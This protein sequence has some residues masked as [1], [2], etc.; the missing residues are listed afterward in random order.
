MDQSLKNAIAGNIEKKLSGTSYI[1]SS[2]YRNKQPLLNAC[3]DIADHF[4]DAIWL[5]IFNG[6]MPNHNFKSQVAEIYRVEML[7]IYQ[8][9]RNEKQDASLTV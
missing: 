1:C 5:P 8:N 7:S 9:R 2:E 3:I 4:V 6:R